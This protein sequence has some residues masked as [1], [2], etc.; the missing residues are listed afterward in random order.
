MKSLYIHVHHKSWKV[1]INE[2]EFDE[3]VDSLERILSSNLTAEGGIGGCWIPVHTNTNH[4]SLSA[5]S[6]I[7]LTYELKKMAILE[8]VV[9]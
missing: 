6:H 2:S 9:E 4:P 1:R 5:E 7:F 3:E 8:T